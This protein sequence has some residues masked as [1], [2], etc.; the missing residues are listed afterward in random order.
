MMVHISAF[1]TPFA[2][3]LLEREI[4]QWVNS[5]VKQYTTSVLDTD[6]NNFTPLFE[7]LGLQL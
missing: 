1:V 4:S 5:P 2:E 6:F 3:H 7:K